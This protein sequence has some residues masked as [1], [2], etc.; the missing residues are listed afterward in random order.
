M[1][2]VLCCLLG[3]APACDNVIAPGAP[4]PAEGAPEETASGGSE[5]CGVIG[6]G[7]WCR[8]HTTTVLGGLLPREIHWQVPTGT[9]PPTGWP[10]ALLFQDALV[11][12]D[13]YW[14]GWPGGTFGGEQ[15]PRLVESLLAAGF[16]VLTPKAQLDGAAGWDTNVIPYAT[17][18]TA[19]PDHQL[20]VA[21][22][23]EIEAGTFGA[24]DADRLYAAG[25]GSG[26]HMASRVAEAYPGRFRA[27]AIHS[28]SYAACAGWLCAV[29]ADLADDHPPTLFLHGGL[30][31]LVPVA[32]TL[33]LGLLP[34]AASSNA[35]LAL[36]GGASFSVTLPLALAST[37]MQAVTP[38]EMRGV[39]NG[40][41]VVTTNVLGLALGPTLV[42]ATTDFVFADTQAVARS[43]AL[44]SAVVGPLA[45]L[46]IW[47]GFDAYRSAS[48]SATPVS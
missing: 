7:T 48:G 2:I 16:A 17:F 40:L 46:L 29:P 38:N 31:A 44:V 19:A 23:D 37:V 47:S 5:R 4:P 6:T 20:M 22:L 45:L 13:W 11:T 3:L 32:A 30:D 39:V 26:G 21:L 8:H 41:Y 27:L 9:P 34:W 14:I 36:I 18:W 1:R 10:V 25:I 35:A 24:L 33:C 43:L 42:A 28:A 15:Q 12:A